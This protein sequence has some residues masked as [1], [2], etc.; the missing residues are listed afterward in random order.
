MMP[1]GSIVVLGGRAT[2]ISI[3]DGAYTRVTVGL[4]D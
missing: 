1:D 2:A 4:K 3:K